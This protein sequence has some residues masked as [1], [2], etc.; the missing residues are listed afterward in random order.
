MASQQFL[1]QRLPDGLRAIPELL[2]RNPLLS[3]DEGWLCNK[4]GDGEVAILRFAS[5]IDF[6]PC[7][8]FVFLNAARSGHHVKVL[9]TC[10]AALWSSCGP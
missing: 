2:R 9:F 3:C 7:E 8:D 10:A 4:E 5:S 1:L 6:H